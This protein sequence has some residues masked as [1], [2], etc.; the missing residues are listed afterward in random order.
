M[1]SYVHPD[2]GLNSDYPVCWSGIVVTRVREMMYMKTTDRDFCYYICEWACIFHGSVTALSQTMWEIV[3]GFELL[4]TS[5]KFLL[6]A[7][8]IKVVF[9]LFKN[10]Y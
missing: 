5:I 1:A 4:H 3:G 9:H 10:G 7:N 2:Y 6:M 8:L